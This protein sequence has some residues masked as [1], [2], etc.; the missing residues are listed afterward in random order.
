MID[1]K[2]L[3]KRFKKLKGTDAL[4][5]MFITDVIKEI[6]Q[7]PKVGEWIPCSERL[8]QK[9]CE[10]F[11]VWLDS[12]VFDIAIWKESGGFCPW[13]AYYFEDVPSEW[14][15]NVLAWMPQPEPYSEG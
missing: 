9:A 3:I 15:G 14:E 6:K 11:L 5:N 4:S 12:R 2:K 7:Q 13:Y 10:C 1:E 8:P